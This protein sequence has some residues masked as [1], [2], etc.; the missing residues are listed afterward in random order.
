MLPVGFIV[1]NSTVVYIIIWLCYDLKHLFPVA[2]LWFNLLMW[3]C[4]Y[5][6]VNENP[7][8]EHNEQVVYMYETNTK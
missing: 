1:K 2:Y 3:K 8:Y 4:N 6:S 5:N 7:K